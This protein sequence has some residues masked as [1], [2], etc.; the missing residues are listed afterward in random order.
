MA[1]APEDGTV[2]V[3]AAE[4]DFVT[5]GFRMHEDVLIDLG[6]LGRIGLGSA[7]EGLAGLADDFVAG[8]DASLIESI[9]IGGAHADEV[10]GYG[11]AGHGVFATILSNRSGIEGGTGLQGEGGPLGS[12]VVGNALRKTGSCLVAVREDELPGCLLG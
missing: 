8:I 5:G 10:L 1:L 11:F 12:A 7:H 3:G 9:G 6:S 2:E 4:D